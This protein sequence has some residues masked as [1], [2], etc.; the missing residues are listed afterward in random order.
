MLMGE[1]A[2]A[3]RYRLPIKVVV[4]KNDHYSR[5][6]SE[7]N[8]LGIHRSEPSCNRLTL[9]ALLKRAEVSVSHARGRRKCAPASILRP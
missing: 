6:M 2:T 3:V 7:D 5:V 9:C 1:F 8:A 4:L